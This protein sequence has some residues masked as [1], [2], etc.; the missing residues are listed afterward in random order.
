MQKSS[1]WS[2]GRIFLRV[3]AFGVVIFIILNLAARTS[4]VGYTTQYRLVSGE[5]LV[6]GKSGGP[7]TA[8]MN[9]ISLE[10]YYNP[11]LFPMSHLS[12]NGKYS[13]ITWTLQ[14]PEENV[15]EVAALIRVF[16]ELPINL[17]YLFTVSFV[18]GLILEELA[19]HLSKGRLE[20][21][22]VMGKGELV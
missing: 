3:C 13:G 8:E 11:L 12:G 14:Y 18:S 1:L 15:E 21:K 20:R 22:G 2:L 19:F 5:A 7:R 6:Y 4:G 17:P 10:I 9:V 16:R